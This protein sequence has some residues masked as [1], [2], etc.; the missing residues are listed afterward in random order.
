MVP[1]QA[2]SSNG[3]LV[4]NDGRL[5]SSGYVVG[6][7]VDG[8]S[9]VLP[10]SHDSGISYW[11]NLWS[12]SYPA[13]MVGFKFKLNQFTPGRQVT[14]F[15][16]VRRS[17]VINESP[18]ASVAIFKDGSLVASCDPYQIYYVPEWT[19]WGCTVNAGVWL[20][21]SGGWNT[22]ALGVTGSGFSGDF[23]DL[24]DV[25]WVKLVVK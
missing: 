21:Q 24:L 22:M 18:Y 20:N 19:N 1:Y 3:M 10:P 11:P 5:A 15:Y 14:L 8:N 12:I 13:D 25:N 6:F 2:G 4:W 7:A 16:R 23:P 17:G 9:R